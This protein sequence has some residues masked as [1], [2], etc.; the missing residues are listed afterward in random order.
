MDPISS[1]SQRP[2]PAPPRP[3]DSTAPGFSEVLSKGLAVAS[4]IASV[5][6]AVV[7][8]A[9]LV[10]VALGGLSRLLGSGGE[11]A[12]TARTAD[13]GLDAAEDLVAQS[14][15]FNVRYI[16]LQERLQRE[17]RAYT[18]ISNIMRVRHEA[19]KNTLANLR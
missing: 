3:R 13:A 8:G 18:A 5:A 15:S 10:S 4:D 1:L 17:S 7:P 2:T 16:L 11:A 12:A 6:G 9:G 14:R 19:A